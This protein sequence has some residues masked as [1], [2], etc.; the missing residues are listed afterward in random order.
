MKNELQIALDKLNNASNTLQEGLNEVNS[1]LEIDGVIQRFEYT[2]EL[3]WKTLK[4]FLNHKE[5]DCQSPRDCLKTTFKQ[6]LIPDEEVYL[7]MLK[8][9]NLSSHIY[10]QQDALKI[11]ENIKTQYNL[12]IIQLVNKLN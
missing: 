11:F 3:A 1:Q 8:D 7:D 6:G 5:V 9:R 10:N 4:V 12:A 2:F